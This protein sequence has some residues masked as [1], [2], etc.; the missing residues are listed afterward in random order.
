MRDEVGQVSSNMDIETSRFCSEILKRLSDRYPVVSKELTKRANSHPQFRDDP[1]AR[2][3]F[4]IALL[5]KEHE[6]KFEEITLFVA[7]QPEFRTIASNPKTSRIFSSIFRVYETA[8]MPGS[9]ESKYSRSPDEGE[10]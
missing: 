4:K 10:F 7:K 9:F 5:R 2:K 1:T 6:V 3:E 8:R